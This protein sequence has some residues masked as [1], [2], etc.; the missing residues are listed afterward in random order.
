M[1]EEFNGQ[2]RDDVRG[3]AGE[4][5]VLT[6][7]DKGRIVINSLTG[8]NAP[9]VKTRGVAGQM[10]FADHA[11][12]ITGRLQRLGHGPLAAVEGIENSDAVDVRIFAGE[13]ARAARGANGIHGEAIVKTQAFVREAVEMRRLV[14]LAA[15][16]ADGVGRVIV[17]HDEENV[18]TRARWGFSRADE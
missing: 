13:N 14:D 8:Q 1:L 16:S 18:R 10:P 6:H 11:R 9:I 2:V 4:F 3:V 15:V 5:F 17:R 12:V 7:F